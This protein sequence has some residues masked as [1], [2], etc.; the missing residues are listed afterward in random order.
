MGAD[1]GEY[2]AAWLPN[3]TGCAIRVIEL[4]EGIQRSME[5]TGERYVPTEQG[6]IRLEHYH[7]YATVLHL[8][9]GKTVLDVACGEGYGSALMSDVASTVTGVDISPDA[10]QH[11]SDTYA[12]KRNLVYRQGSATALQF[13]D[14]SFDVVISFETI[15]HLAEQA[16]MLA[17]IRRVLREDGVLIISSPNRP[18][19]SEESGEHNEFHVKELDFYEFDALLKA[20][21]PVTEYYGQRIMMGSV[22]QP[23]EGGHAAYQ[24]WYDDGISIKPRTVKL[25]DPVYF[26]ALCGVSDKTK[27]PS[28]DPSVVY[29]DKLDLVKHYV[30]FA[31]WAQTL[32]LTVAERDQQVHTLMDLLDKRDRDAQARELDAQ[33]RDRDARAA[34]DEFQR[35]SHQRERHIS[36]LRAYLAKRD[37]YVATAEH[38]V[39]TAEYK[40]VARDNDITLLLAE[41]ALLE[42]SLNAAESNFDALVRSSSWKITWPMRELKRWVATPKRQAERYVRVGRRL[43][44]LQLAGTSET[45]SQAGGALAEI[46]PGTQQLGADSAA[47]PKLSDL[48]HDASFVNLLPVSDAPLI[49]IV[50]PVY[51][52]I[53]YTLRCLVSIGKNPPKADFEIVIVDDC[54]PDSTVEILSAIRTVGVV[55]NAE[56]QG[57]V[58]SC[59][60]GAR[61]AKGEYLHFL[62]NDTEVAEGWLDSMLDVFSEKSDCGMVG[63]KLVYPD[64]RLQEAGGIVWKDASAWNF[65]RLDDPNKSIYNYRKPVD[66]CSGASLLIRADLFETLGR[67]DERYVPAY[68][69]DVDLAFKVRESGKVLYYQP[70]S[71]V[72]HFEGI[73]NGTDTGVGIKTYQVINQNKFFDRWGSVLERDQFGNGETVFKARDR[74]QNQK[75]ILVIDHYIPQPDRD[76]GSRCMICYMTQFLVMGMRV[77]FWP[78]NLAYDKDYAT[79]LQRMG[80]EVIYGGEYARGFDEWIRQHGL[81]ID[82]AF[83]SRPYVS[84]E[85]I[86]GL[87]AYSRAK[88]L[89][90]GV[91]LHFARANMEFEVT[92]DPRLIAEAEYIR[93]E[94][95][96]IWKSVD[97]VYYPS[98]TETETV[99]SMLPN[100]NARTLPAYYYAPLAD[101]PPPFGAR[102]DLL[103]VAGF[104]HPPN[105]DAALWLVKEILPLVRRRYPFIKLTLVG[106]NPTPEVLELA[107]D[108]ITVTGYVTDSQLKRYYDEARVAVVPLRFGAGVKNK[109]VEAM[110]NGVALV[111]TSIG[112][113]GLPGLEK[114][115]PVHDDARLFAD[116]VSRL[117]DD[118][119]WSA[120]VSE[121]GRVYVQERFS[122]EAMRKVLL[123]DLGS[124]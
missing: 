12:D 52:K 8:V 65:G 55:R 44:R 51:G 47:E 45:V 84:A 29:P 7:R 96:R 37:E 92:G 94:E 20:Q 106:S 48:L 114:V 99:L 39:A 69:E 30:G 2:L 24:A 124:L 120:Q 113:Q 53:D 89:Y 21:F 117:L 76:A 40:V 122:F 109:V 104:G 34:A 1:A 59:N 123:A 22:I 107:N 50:I 38:K 60:V 6:R 72:T 27:L 43:L 101:V 23:L 115:L 111:T 68:Y 83:L 103:F 108:L 57:F 116:A 112:A 3:Q 31:K 49:S 119:I 82:F 36:G 105:V 73:S 67:F 10:V 28:L 61:A 15:E 78:Q 4:L 80:V 54:S 25:R 32:D 33:A 19:Y 71:V 93:G 118:G 35:A 85:F 75:T 16:E 87:S 66:Y 63:S 14:A 56:N 42:V 102:H 98:H 17:E 58:R 74:S 88:L 91:D 110:H 9:S 77:I 97:V 81:Y 26:L 79:P 13:P 100:V 11:A 95:L 5:F 90:F 18:V 64:G 86:P 46:I 70:Q 41:K 121:Q 62:N